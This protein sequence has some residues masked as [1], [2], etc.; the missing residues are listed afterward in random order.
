MRT[1]KITLRVEDEGQSTNDLLIALMDT[2]DESYYEDS[3]FRVVE[4]WETEEDEWADEP[5]HDDGPGI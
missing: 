3:S 4:L 2:F 5:G 1:L